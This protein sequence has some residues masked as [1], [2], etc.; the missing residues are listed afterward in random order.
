MFILTKGLGHE[1]H[2]LHLI[3]MTFLTKCQVKNLVKIDKCPSKSSWLS[4][5]GHIEWIMFNQ[6][7]HYDLTCSQLN[8]IHLIS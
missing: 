8:H 6:I 1:K 5:I 3:K 2:M 4:Q 7:D